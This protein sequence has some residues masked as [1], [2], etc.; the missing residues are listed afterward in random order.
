MW[1]LDEWDD[2]AIYNIFDDI[3]G[4]L[5]SFDYKGF[6]GAQH[7]L[8]VADKYKK[9]RKIQNGKPCIYISNSDP[10]KTRKGKDDRDWLLANCIFVYVDTPLCNIARVNLQREK[11]EKEDEELEQTLNEALAQLQ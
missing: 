9:K 6:L 7:E 8:T 5:N 11:E 10:L 1:N 3:P 2:S 4:Q